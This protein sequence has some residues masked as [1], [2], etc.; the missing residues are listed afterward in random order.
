MKDYVDLCF[1]A[2]GRQL[3]TITIFISKALVP[4][5]RLQPHV[6]EFRAALARLP[7]CRIELKATAQVAHK[8][9]IGYRR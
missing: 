8:I 9:E 6:R 5:D 7:N 4:Q 2:R 3:A 1:I